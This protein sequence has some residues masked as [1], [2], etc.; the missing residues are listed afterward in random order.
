MIVVVEFVGALCT[1][2]NVKN[3][4]AEL[5]EEATML[6]LM[7]RLKAELFDEEESF[8][9]TNLLIMRNGREISALNG[10]QTELEHE[11]KVTLIP[12]S[13]GG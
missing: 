10:L 5:G 13:H 2:A 4:S 9:E 3:Y 6:S 7:Q 12:I 1:I 11:D 8:D